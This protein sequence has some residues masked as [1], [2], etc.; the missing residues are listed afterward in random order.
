VTFPPGRARTGDES[1]LNWIGAAHHDNGDRARGVLRIQ[2]CSRTK[3]YD[4]VDFVLEKLRGLVA[5]F[6]DDI[7][8]LDVTQLL[9]PFFYRSRQIGIGS[10]RQQKSDAVNLA[11][12]LSFERETKRQKQSPKN[13]SENGSLHFI[14]HAFSGYSLLT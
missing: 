14:L 8:P 13:Q 6:N 5:L 1:V 2:R 9:Q 10:R 7:L 12:L 4:N 3:H 11:S